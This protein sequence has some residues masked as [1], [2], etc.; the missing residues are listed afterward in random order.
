MEALGLNAKWFLFQLLNF[1]VLFVGLS[2]L[3]HKPLLK[4]IDERRKE[5]KQNHELAQKLRQEAAESEVRHKEIID[6]AK[7]QAGQILS[8]AKKQGE[9]L[10]DRLE[11]QAQTQAENILQKAKEEIARQK[12][13]MKA[14]LKEEL[15]DIVIG[16]SEKVLNS[17]LADSEKKNQVK[18]ILK[19]IV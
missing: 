17:Q 4:F 10:E 6:Q 8:A 9:E 7:A 3:L 12:D 11:Q 15:T 19:E 5:A 13:Q 1:I 18:Q 2:H 14:E 16:A